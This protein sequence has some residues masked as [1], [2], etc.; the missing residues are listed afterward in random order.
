M[1]TATPTHDI[2]SYQMLHWVKG[3]TKLYSRDSIAMAVSNETARPNFDVVHKRVPD[4]SVQ[5]VAGS[6]LSQKKA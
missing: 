3:D 6:A 1:W 2:T 4:D 5:A